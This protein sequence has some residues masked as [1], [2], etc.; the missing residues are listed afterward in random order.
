MQKRILICLRLIIACFIIAVSCAETVVPDG[1]QITEEILS[2]YSGQEII[3]S[4]QVQIVRNN[5]NFRESP[6]GKVLGRLQG[7]TVLDCLDEAQ[8]QGKLW[9]RVRSA[10]YGDGYVAGTYAKPV[11]NHSDWWQQPGTE[12][13]I[14]DNMVLFAYWMGTYQLD[15]GL[16]VIETVGSER[17]L[18][19]APMS[20]RG[21]PSV[22]PEDMK[23]RLAEKLFEYGFICRNASYGR[24]TDPDVSFEDQNNTAV[25]VLQ[26][27]YGTD[28]I[29]SI[30]T[31]QST[32]LFIHVNDLHAE[33]EASL[34]GRDQILQSAVMKKLIEEH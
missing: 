26:K 18:S 11:W 6:G 21:N 19:I 29:W 20:V 10:E 30:I 23:I 22:I 33:P 15:H 24:L 2:S 4:D 3:L 7:G 31:K 14:T 9:Y 13:V 5:V 28:D 17:Q 27:H 32:A 16:S 25:S 12:N 34:S 1:Q 8:H